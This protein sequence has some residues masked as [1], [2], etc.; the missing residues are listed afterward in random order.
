M[1]R[2]SEYYLGSFSYSPL[3]LVVSAA[4]FPR[5]RGLYHFKKILTEK[6][7]QDANKWEDMA[8]VSGAFRSGASKLTC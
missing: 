4:A 2:F 8:R 5:W 6:A 3:L 7:Y 1:F